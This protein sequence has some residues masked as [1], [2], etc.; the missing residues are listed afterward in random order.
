[1]DVVRG[2]RFAGY[3][4]TEGSQAKAHAK[5]HLPTPVPDCAIPVLNAS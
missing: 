2:R 1:M 4:E 5:Y 3:I